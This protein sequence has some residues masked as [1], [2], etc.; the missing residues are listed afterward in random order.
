MTTV[1]QVTGLPVYEAMARLQRAG[2]YSELARIPALQHSTSRRPFDAYIVRKQS[3]HAGTRVRW[4]GILYSTSHGG[5][6]D[7]GHSQVT[8]V[9]AFK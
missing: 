3:P 9:L 1:P 7:V 6:V 8:L 2:V 5:T 4:A